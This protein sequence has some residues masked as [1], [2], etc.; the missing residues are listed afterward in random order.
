MADFQLPMNRMTDEERKKLIEKDNYE[1]QKMKK[2]KQI[3]GA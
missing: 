1:K 3:R 2:E